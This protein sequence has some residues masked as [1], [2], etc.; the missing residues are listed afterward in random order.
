MAQPLLF[1]AGLLICFARW[2]HSVEHIWSWLHRIGLVDLIKM[3][4]RCFLIA[5]AD[6][7]DV[8]DVTGVKH[9]SWLEKL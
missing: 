6:E 2:H 9:G 1:T 3:E 8:I 4:E 5:V 7:L